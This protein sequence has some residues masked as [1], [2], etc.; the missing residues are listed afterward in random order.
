M[1]Q[2]TNRTRSIRPVFVAYKRRGNNAGTAIKIIQS[3]P[4]LDIDYGS[5]KERMQNQYTEQDSINETSNITMLIRSEKD[6]SA[7]KIM[8]H[9]MLERKALDEGGHCQVYMIFLFLRKYHRAMPRTTLRK[10]ESS[11]QMLPH[12]R[13]STMT[14]DD[15]PRG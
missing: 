7:M 1:T 15:R 3:M 14:K 4:S 2:A 11:L 13:T 6:W 10:C 12:Y 9:K 5:K 8:F